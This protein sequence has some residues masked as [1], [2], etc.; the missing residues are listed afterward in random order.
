MVGFLIC[1]EPIRRPKLTE[2]DRK[3][4][5][6]SISG[7]VSFYILPL[8][9]TSEEAIAGLDILPFEDADNIDFLC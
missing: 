6:I 9:L 8:I 1:A 3:W 4:D 7:L 5:G 2:L